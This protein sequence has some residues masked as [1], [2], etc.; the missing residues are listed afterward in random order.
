MTATNRISARRGE[1]G[2]THRAS[3]LLA[4]GQP[5][6][7]DRRQRIIVGAPDP[8]A[9]PFCARRDALVIIQGPGLPD[10]PLLYHVTCDSCGADGPEAS[11][12]RT[13]A[14]L[15]NRLGV[16]RANRFHRL[17]CGPGEA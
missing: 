7:R 3:R 12:R 10:T 6:F 11:S 13:A 4:P 15:W 2:R 9:C 14:A 8:E 16:T 1:D 17:L 5:C